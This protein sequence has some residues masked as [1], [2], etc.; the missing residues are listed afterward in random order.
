MKS[1]RQVTMLR[2]LDE[3]DSLKPDEDAIITHSIFGVVTA[4]YRGLGKQFNFENLNAVVLS[5]YQKGYG[6]PYIFTLGVDRRQLSVERGT[7]KIPRSAFLVGEPSGGS[8]IYRDNKD[9]PLL[10]EKINNV[11]VLV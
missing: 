8:F 2:S 1:Q 3:I 4:L 11:K 7:L 9:Y 6:L 5:L 10:L